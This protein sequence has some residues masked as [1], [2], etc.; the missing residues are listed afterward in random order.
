MSKKPNSY[1]SLIGIIAILAS[2]FLI[3]ISFPDLKII[4]YFLIQGVNF[5]DINML[6]IKVIFYF[7]YANF[8]SKWAL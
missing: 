7:F 6:I 8:S 2:I 3:Y 5:G 4:Y 1:N